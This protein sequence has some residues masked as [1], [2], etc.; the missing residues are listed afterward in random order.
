MYSWRSRDD[1]VLARV[2]QLAVHVFDPGIVLFITFPYEKK[3]YLCGCFRFGYPQLIS[4]FV[5]S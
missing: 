5:P 4:V 1:G 2:A 3:V